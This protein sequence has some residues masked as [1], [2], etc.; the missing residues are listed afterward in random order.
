MLHAGYGHLT[1]EKIVLMLQHDGILVE[2]DLKR[3]A[4]KVQ[5]KA[6]K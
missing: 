5:L 2:G 1:V 6:Y 3:V 4:A